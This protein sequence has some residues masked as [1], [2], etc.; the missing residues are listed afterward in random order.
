[1]DVHKT[2]GNR[3]V[4]GGVDA[5]APRLGIWRKNGRAADFR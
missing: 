1:M 4:T 2:E 5:Q 3:V